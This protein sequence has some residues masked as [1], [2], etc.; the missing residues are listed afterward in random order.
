[1]ADQIKTEIPAFWQVLTLRFVDCR[2]PVWYTPNNQ[3]VDVVPKGRLVAVDCQIQQ[4]D[5]KLKPELLVGLRDAENY[6]LLTM[7]LETPAALSLI[8]P[9]C[10]L[11]DSLIRSHITLYH[12]FCTDF[13]E[14]FIQFVIQCHCKLLNVPLSDRT[15]WP[16]LCMRRL[17]HLQQKLDYYSVDFASL[18]W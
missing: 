2:S 15:V 18:G 12:E 14:S 1:M 3:P 10:V 5:N 4:S 8:E 17:A 11:P 7:G 16:Q 9:L 13:T 6:Q